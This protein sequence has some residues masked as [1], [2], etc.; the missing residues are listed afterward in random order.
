MKRIKKLVAVIICL[1]V[2]FLTACGGDEKGTYYPNA[3]EM[4]KNLEEE[5]YA[6]VVSNDF[7]IEYTGTYLYAKK[8]QEYIVFYWLN[9]A[10]AVGEFLEVIDNSDAKGKY[11]KIVSLENDSKFGNI[12][13]HGTSDAIDDAGIK[14][15]DVKVK[16]D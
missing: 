15:V 13:F 3:E 10:E 7:H 12:V 4:Q 5:G 16:V 11:D 6:V 2:L 9:E 1:S 8:A 14:I